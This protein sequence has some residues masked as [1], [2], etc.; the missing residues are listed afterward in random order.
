MGGGVR[1]GTGE[2]RTREGGYTGGTS[3]RRWPAPAGRISSAAVRR[4]RLRVGLEGPG[5]KVARGFGPVLYSDLLASHFAASRGRGLQPFFLPRPLPPGRDP[6]ARFPSSN[7]FACGPRAG[8]GGGGA[9][10]AGRRGGR[11]EPGGRG[12]SASGAT[13][14]RGGLSS[15]RSRPRRVAQGG[16]R[17]SPRRQGS[18]AM[19]VSHPTR[20]ET[21]TKE[22]NARASQ[23]DRFLF[24]KPRGAM[25]VRAG[26][27][28]PR[29]DPGP[30]R[31]LSS[32]APPARLARSVGEVERERAR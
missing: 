26:A 30:P 9:W 6:V 27:R 21:R 23:R 2:E 32:G 14:D 17:P 24:S 22:S 18:A 7:L 28:R 15:V 25:K 12:P 4:D 10:S 8:R 20:L 3:P 11:L 31:G 5:A 1:T 19:S 13:H 16:E 29:W